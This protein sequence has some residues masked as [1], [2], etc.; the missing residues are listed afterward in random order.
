MKF[1]RSLSARD[2]G[3]FFFGFMMALAVVLAYDWQDFKRGFQDGYEA[4]SEEQPYD[5][6]SGEDNENASSETMEAAVK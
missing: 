5:A 6:E 3:F 1:F 2:L 4:A